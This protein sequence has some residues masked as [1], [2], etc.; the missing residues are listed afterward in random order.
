MASVQNNTQETDSKKG[1]YAVSRTAS[2]LADEFVDPSLGQKRVITCRPP[3]TQDDLER[4]PSPPTRIGNPLLHL[5]GQMEERAI[6]LYREDLGLQHELPGLQRVRRL[7]TV[8]DFFEDVL[9]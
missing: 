6:V 9:H 8:G 7:P 3:P 1:F 5:E 2:V 4:L